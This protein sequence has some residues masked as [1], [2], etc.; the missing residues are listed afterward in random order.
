MFPRKSFDIFHFF[1]DHGLSLLTKK[2]KYEKAKLNCR[3]LGDASLAQFHQRSRYSFY[4]CRSQMRKKRQS[5]QQCHLALLGPMSLKAASKTLVKLTPGVN[6]T[7]VL[8]AAFTRARSQKS[9][10]TMMT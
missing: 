8:G 10:K 6:F 2:V 7:N 5:S 9:K 4:A 1:D 3:G